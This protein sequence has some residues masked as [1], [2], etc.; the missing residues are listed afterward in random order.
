MKAAITGGAGRQSLSAIYDFVETEDV[1]KVLLIDINEEALKARKELVGSPKIETKAI[2]LKDTQTL[3]QALEE[4]DVVINGSSH[5]FNMDVMDACIESKT[6]YTDFGGLFHWAVEQM[7]RDEDFRRAGITGIVGSGSAPGIVNVLT[8]YATDRLDT[9]EDILILDA[10]INRS[11]SGYGFV[12]PYALNTII[13][14]FTMN[15]FEYK[16]GEHVELPPFS[17]KMTVDFPE[18]YGTLN[19]YNMIHSEVAT[20]PIAYKDKGIKNVAFKLALPTLFEERLR[21][22]IENGLGSQEKINVKGTAIAPRDFLLEVFET[23]PG[24]KMGTPDDMKLLRVIV[25]GTKD[26]KKCTYEVETD[27]HHHPWGLSNGHF[28]VGF[29]GAITAKMLAR[30]QVKEKGFF[31]GEQVLDTDIYFRE[32]EK[33]NVHVFAKVTE[34]L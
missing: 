7:G 21:F 32:L 24:T 15:N 33:R 28:S 12:P 27:L 19:L 18:P 17:G 29:P 4:Y 16:D 6:N 31:T 22:L 8:K 34:Q 9:V 1:E 25:T 10:I 11:A 3:A 30:G 5:V 20:M 13:E 26:G 2:D 14:E 23:K